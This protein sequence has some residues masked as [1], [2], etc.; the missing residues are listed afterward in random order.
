MKKL[1]FLF[2]IGL[3]SILASC[4]E[5][6]PIR[7]AEKPFMI[8]SRSIVDYN[9]SASTTNPN[10]LTN[11]E[12][13]EFIKINNQNNVINRITPPWRNGASTALPSNFCKDIKKEDGWKMLFHTFKDEDTDYGMSY[14]F[15]YNL[16]TGTVKVFYYYDG[17][18]TATNSQWVFKNNDNDNT[19]LNLFYVPTYISKVETDPIPYIASGIMKSNELNLSNS[20]ISQG[21]NGFQYKVSQYSAESYD[22]NFMIAAVSNCVTYHKFEGALNMGTSGKITSVTVPEVTS[23][24]QANNLIKSVAHLGGG[25]AKDYISGLRNHSKNSSQGGSNDNFKGKLFGSLLNL[26]GEVAEKGV[27]AL[28]KKGLGIIFGQTSTVTVYNTVSDVDLTTEGSVSIHGISNT[29]QTSGVKPITFN[30]GQILSGNN[31]SQSSAE[32]NDIAY[33]QASSDISLSNLGVWCV[34]KHP[35]AYFDLMKPFHIEESTDMETHEPLDVRGTASFPT[36]NYSNIEIQFNPAIQQYITSYTVDKSYFFANIKGHKYISQQFEALPTSENK[37][38]QDT[39][40][41][42]YDTRIFGTQDRFN[43]LC[44][45][46]SNSVNSDSQ[47]YFYWRIPSSCELLALV[48]VTMNISYMGKSRSIAESRIVEV[49]TREQ[50]SYI[51]H[52]PP[53]R[54]ILNNNYTGWKY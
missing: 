11:W 52:Q 5:E 10:L 47:F 53:Y 41:T 51:T 29:D 50:P 28:I 23:T 1:I 38:Y 24:N 27:G 30:L 43:I 40:K 22:H 37:V 44:D 36:V 14:M 32:S 19:S 16:F 12:N 20:A 48:T 9:D 18:V 31:C 15:F 7:E 45:M 26:A 17:S 35:V 8:E 39:T 25:A 3:A 54:V 46:E 6:V 21:W 13:V 2:L 33:Q 49:E 42:I 4:T 34:K